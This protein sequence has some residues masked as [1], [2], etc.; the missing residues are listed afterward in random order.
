MFSPTQHIAA[1]VIAC[2]TLL[3]PHAAF[4]QVHIETGGLVFDSFYSPRSEY[5][6]SD[7]NG[8]ATFSLVN[9]VDRMSY[10]NMTNY[11]Q[12]YGSIFQLTAREGYRVTGYSV[13]GG[14]YGTHYVGQSPNGSGEPGSASSGAAAWAYA[15]DTPGGASFA[16]GSHSVSNLNGHSDFRID[17]GALDKTGSFY[18][19][20]D[21]YA[22]GSAS[23]ATW[24][25]PGQWWPSRA[26]SAAEVGLKNPLLLTVYTQAVPEPHTYAMTLAGLALLAGVVRRRKR[27]VQKNG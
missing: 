14:F 26:Y 24:Y 3:A 25:K 5:L 12:D 18:F 22:A 15:S 4:A 20:F 10:P 16:Y 11:H 9:A 6:V 8:A 7:M 23:P 19:S 13:S 1:A 21:G 17:S 2:S 27:T